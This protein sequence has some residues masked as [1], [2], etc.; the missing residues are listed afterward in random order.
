MV[1][2]PSI[3]VNNRVYKGDISGQELALA[4]CAA[5]D[6]RPDECDLSWKIEAFQQG[7]ITDFQDLDMPDQE[8]YILEAANA[9][10]V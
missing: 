8:D 4:I 1:F 5:F 9:K 6:E 2:H 7:M 10:K 3:A